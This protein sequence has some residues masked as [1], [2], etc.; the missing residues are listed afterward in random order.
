MWCSKMTQNDTLAPA[1]AKGGQG[2]PRVRVSWLLT[3]KKWQ[4]KRSAPALLLLETKEWPQFG[5]CGE[6]LLEKITRRNFSPGLPQ[7]EKEKN[8]HTAITGC[9]AFP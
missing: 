3:Q 6:T 4:M 1:A 5:I 2:S 9:C 8:L 7:E